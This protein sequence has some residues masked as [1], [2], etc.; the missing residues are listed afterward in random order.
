MRT[1]RK[2]IILILVT[3]II[4]TLKSTTQVNIFASSSLNSNNRKIA[5]IAVIVHRLDD[6]Y[7][8]RL[9]ESL[10]N[11]EKD[12]QNNVK[13]TFFDGKNNISIQ[14]EIIDSAIR[15]NYDLLILNLADKRENIVVDILNRTKGENIPVILMNISPEVVSK[16]SNIYD[17][18][19]FVLPDS[20][21]AGTSEGKIIIDLWNNKKNSIDK[22]GDGI[23][24]YVL[25]KGRVNDP[26]AI[27][28]TKY[29]ISTINDSGIKTQEIAL[30][31]ANWLKEL[32]ESSINNLFLKYNGSIEAII[33]NNDAMAIGAIEALQKYGYNKGDNSKNIAVI[34]IDGLPESK[35]LID[36]GFMTGTVIQDSNVL[37]QMLYTIGINLINNLTSTENTNYKTVN[38]E[39]II[40][41]PYDIYMGKLNAP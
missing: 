39:I 26:Q 37:A 25:L 36:K 40:P 21:Q 35:D 32:A 24:Q 13:F 4:L 41:Y 15:N 6:T 22:N 3:L 19:A 20:K 7:M 18:V 33:S 28:R 1:V 9:R 16:V 34:G 2:I 8:I 30:I 11:I 12:K 29:V 10:E 27:D 17:K 5:N 38:G 14:N 23:L 31:D